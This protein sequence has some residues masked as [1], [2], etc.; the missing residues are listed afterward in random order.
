MKVS[1]VRSKPQQARAL[2]CVQMLPHSDNRTALHPQI[3]SMSSSHFRHI[4]KRSKVGVGTGDLTIEQKI[5]REV[6]Y[7]HYEMILKEDQPTPKTQTDNSTKE[8]K[9]KVVQCRKPE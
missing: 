3:Q 7:L 6:A 5:G 8:R 2:F 1:G 4:L 9:R